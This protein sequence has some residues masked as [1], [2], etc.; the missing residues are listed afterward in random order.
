MLY[1]KLALISLPPIT[2]VKASKSFNRVHLR[3]IFCV[4]KLIL[5]RARKVARTMRKPKI[6][7]F[8]PINLAALQRA[9][10]ACVYCMWLRFQRNYVGWPKSR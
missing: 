5:K 4:Y 9:F 7:R 1:S 3:T 6:D 8:Y 2:K 10:H